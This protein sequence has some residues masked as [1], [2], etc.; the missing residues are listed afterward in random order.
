MERELWST[1]D[2]SL[3]ICFA[4][5]EHRSE[6]NVGIKGGED[7]GNVLTGF[8]RDLGWCRAGQLIPPHQADKKE[9]NLDFV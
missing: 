9:K 7:N 8:Q 3:F 5:V 6:D 4:T 2:F 1:A